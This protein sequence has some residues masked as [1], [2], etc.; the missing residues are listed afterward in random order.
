MLRFTGD[1]VPATA[2]VRL[3][4]GSGVT[5][6]GATVT[7]RAAPARVLAVALPRLGD[8]TYALVW[9]VRSA[10]GGHP[11]S[12]VLLFGVRAGA[13]PGPALPY[14]PVR[15]LALAL[16]TLAVAL[17]VRSRIR[18]R[19]LARLA[20][21]ATGFALAA[22]LYGFAAPAAPAAASAPPTEPARGQRVD[23]V[24]RE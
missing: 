1:V 24:G 22:G 15:W 9:Q 20:V 16:L 18:R 19:S 12:G 2:S 5:I 3:T 4:D 10:D 7:T 8:G 6:P 17:V 13:A 11:A 21:L 14:G 23:H